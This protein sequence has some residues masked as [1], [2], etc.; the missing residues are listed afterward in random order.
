MP[1]DDEKTTVTVSEDAAAEAPAKGG[2]KQLLMFG[3]IGV[4]LLLIGVVLAVFV[5]GPM[6]AGNDGGGDT[7][8]QV[9]IQPHIVAEVVQREMG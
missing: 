3:G 2:S 5:I 1:A 6:M 8:S 9:E 7:A 4:A